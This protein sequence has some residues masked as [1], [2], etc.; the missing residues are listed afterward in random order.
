[1]S[2]TRRLYKTAEVLNSLLTDSIDVHNQF[3]HIPKQGFFSKIFRKPKLPNYEL[4]HD[5]CLAIINDI[6]KTNIEISA[7]VLMGN[8]EEQRI[9]EIFM[10][11]I[12]PFRLEV[13][14]LKDILAMICDARLNKQPL[15]EIKFNTLINQYECYQKE[16]LQY[17]PQMN[18]SINLLRV[19][20]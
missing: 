6:N 13:T 11:Y 2:Q 7:A 9:A 14:T 10:N 15:E 12:E 18:E 17:G 19:M 1:M 3:F 4:L 8:E 20:N 16:R 5:M